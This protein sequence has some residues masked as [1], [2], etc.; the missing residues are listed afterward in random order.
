MLGTPYYMSPE[1]ARGE[2]VITP[3]TDLYSL[4]VMLYEMLIGAVPISGENYNQLMYRVM[5]SEFVWPR[6][7]RSEI[8]EALEQLIVHAMASDPTHRPRSAEEFEQALLMFCRPNYREHQIE[9]ISQTGFAPALTPTPMTKSQASLQYAG[10][11]PNTPVPSLQQAPAKKSKKGLIIGIIAMMV[12]G[13]GIAAAVVASTSTGKLDPI[14]ATPT[15]GPI[16]PTP[17]APIAV[18]P[19]PPKPPVV[20]TVPLI[21]IKFAV[22]PK[23]AVV[24]VDGTRIE[25][26]LEVRKD[27]APHKLHVSA[28]GY[29]AHDEDIHYDMTQRLTVELAKQAAAAPVGTKL[30]KPPT[31]GKKPD[32]IENQ[33]PY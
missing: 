29:A 20:E 17:P 24:E 33:S 13:G 26:D 30:P 16:A 1:Q 21:Q 15:P 22:T 19:T 6:Q 4:G 11:S 5:T 2:H 7:I 10:T 31:G 32:K 12:I 27:D 3:S 18:A 14:V 25:G 8:P 23:T 9:R 28:P